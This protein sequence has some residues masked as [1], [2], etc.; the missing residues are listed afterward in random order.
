MAEREVKV[1][2]RLTAEKKEEFQR[3]AEE[4]GIT[5]SALGAYVIGNFLRTQKKV[6]DPLVVEMAG[7]AKQ[8]VE[9][10]ASEAKAEA[11]EWS[12]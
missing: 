6:L 3:L 10:V 9:R 1:I 4:L 11:E 7:V 5:M 12:A 2:V 8:A